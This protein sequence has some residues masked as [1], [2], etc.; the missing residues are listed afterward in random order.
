M[1]EY[2]I[3]Q[4]FTLL[5]RAKRSADGKTILPVLDVMDKMGADGFLQDVPFYPCNQ[6]LKERIIR[7]TSRPA[8]TRRAFYAG[9]GSSMMTTQV[10]FENVILFEARRAIDEDE[11]N[12]VENPDEIRRTEDEA[13]I[14]GIIDEVVKAIFVDAR[15]T[16]SLYFDGLITRAST[17]SYPHHTTE[18]LPYCWNNGGSS[19]STLCSVWVV[20]WGKRACYGLYPSGNAV[21]GARLGIIAK[22]KGLEPK[23]D[24][25]D[26]TLTYYNDVAQFKMWCGLAIAD[27]RKFFRIANVSHDKT[28]AYAF[29][30]DL[31]IEALNHAKINR[32]AARMYVN[33]YVATQIDIRAKDKTNVNWSTN[34]IFGKP[35]RTFLGLP[36]RVLD[37]TI[38]TGTESA[39][40]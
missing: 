7:N 4:Q 21:R 2:N 17:L 40:G 32:A 25:T 37:E 20:E 3:N 26:T 33:P 36:I 30:D 39:I 22:N 16:G 11:L 15:S 12:T 19:A 38:L 24:T 18:T 27:D 23:A 8:P 35:V 10:L 34:E 9:V 13:K 6:G 14:K 29:N 28:S 1:T 5:E 31:L